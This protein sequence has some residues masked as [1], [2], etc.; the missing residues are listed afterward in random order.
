MLDGVR[1]PWPPLQ[2][3]SPFRPCL[4]KLWGRLLPQ[5][6][7]AILSQPHPP[8]QSRPSGTLIAAPLLSH[9]K[10]PALASDRDLLHLPP[11][12]DCHSVTLCTCSSVAVTDALFTHGGLLTHSRGGTVT[13][14]EPQCHCTY[15]GRAEN[16]H[17]GYANWG[18]T[19]LLPAL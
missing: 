9:W 4:C 8:A 14:V 12:N 1:G 17:P 18:F 10:L 2:P 5:M 6:D 3:L 13:T 11:H 15:G 7:S 16:P 19:P